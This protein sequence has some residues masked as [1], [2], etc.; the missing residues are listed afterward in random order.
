MNHGF[1]CGEPRRVRLPEGDSLAAVNT[2]LNPD[3]G[4]DKRDTVSHSLE[5]FNNMTAR[6]ADNHG[7][8]DAAKVRDLM[9]L[10]LFN[11]DGAYA[12][13]IS[14]ETTE[15][16]PRSVGTQREENPMSTR[17]SRV[18]RHGAGSVGMGFR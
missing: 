8:I 17:L 11:D 2:F 9:D 6:L 10:T 15:H 16:T 1:G 12:A 5:R 13:P 14:P 3:W 7:A 4:I 18:A